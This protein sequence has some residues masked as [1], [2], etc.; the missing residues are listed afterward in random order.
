VNA[1]EIRDMTNDEIDAKVESVRT[2][3]FNLRFRA[4]FEETDSGLIRTLR[5]DI[6]RLKT[7]RHERDLAAVGDQDG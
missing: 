1:Q 7:I 2:E 4:S 5:R 3:L 6:A